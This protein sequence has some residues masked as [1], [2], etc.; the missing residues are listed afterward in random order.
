MAEN[1]NT[2]GAQAPSANA[3]APVKPAANKA[4]RIQPT[5]GKAAA[6]KG[7]ASPAPKAKGPKKKVSGAL[8]VGL[9]FIIL[10]AVGLGMMY[11]DLYGVRDFAVSAFDLENPTKNQLNAV[12][13]KEQALLDKEK[14]LA[15]R[16][17]ALAAEQDKETQVQKELNKE[18]K[19][20]EKT[21]ADK[22]KELAKLEATI[23]A[24]QAELDALAASL[25][26]KRIDISTAV[27][28]FAGMEPDKAADAMEGI[29]NPADIALLL[30]YMDSEKSAAILDE[31]KTKLATSVML[32][33][34]TLK[35]ANELP[36]AP[37]PTPSSK[38]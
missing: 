27:Q 12:S 3:A 2:T 5:A 15:D 31:M 23:A 21:V 29:E 28:M 7:N 30:L 25:E 1:T 18:L 38:K 24:K 20:R 19:A 13:Q 9:L 11:F 35:E 32:E 17:A 37:A 14:D 8:V 10:I 26:I 33:I 4:S 34:A 22:E 36:P 6:V 16:E